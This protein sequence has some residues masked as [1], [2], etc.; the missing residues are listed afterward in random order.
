MRKFLLKLISVLL[1]ALGIATLSYVLLLNV[2]SPEFDMISK[3]T[4]I[5]DGDTFDTND[6]DRIRLADIN[7][8]ENG[9]AGYEQA[10]AYLDGLIYGETVYLDIDDLYRWDNTGERLVCV[11]YVS[12]NV[13]HYMNVNMALLEVDYA[14]VWEHD[15]EFNPSTWSLYT[16]KVSPESRKNL[17]IISAVFGTVST[18]IIVFIIWRG[19][20]LGK[21]FVDRTDGWVRNLTGRDERKTEENEN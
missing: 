10:T 6:G 5:V 1:L 7:T 3:V 2:V 21:R 16:S 20:Q 18:V 11:V 19:F 14:V 15:N 9:E 4:S 8:P 17:L 13:T 12:H